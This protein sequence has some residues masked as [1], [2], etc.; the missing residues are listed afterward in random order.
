MR[1]VEFTARPVSCSVNPLTFDRELCIGCGC[2]QYI[3]PARIPLVQ[4]FR[5]AK[6]AIRQ[7][8]AKK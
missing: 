5:T 4:Q 7:Q 2:C 6:F 1:K 8:A 3:C